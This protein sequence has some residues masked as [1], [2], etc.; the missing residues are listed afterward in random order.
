MGT[1]N[2][3]AL[4]HRQSSLLQSEERLSNWIESFRKDAECTFGI[5][6]G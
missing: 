2:G 4:K 6:K 1:I 5:L 3:L